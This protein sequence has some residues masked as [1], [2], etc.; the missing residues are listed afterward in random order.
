MFLVGGHL[1]EH[2]P[3]EQFFTRPESDKAAAFLRGDIV[4]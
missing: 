3:A 4:E 1:I 2:A